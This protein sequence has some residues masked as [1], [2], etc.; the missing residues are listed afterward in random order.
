MRIK[1]GVIKAV[2]TEAD[3]L[4][5]VGGQELKTAFSK[6]RNELDKNISEAITTGDMSKAFATIDEM[7]A[8]NETKAALKEVVRARMEEDTAMKKQ[9][10]TE[11]VIAMAARDARRALD[12]LAAGL[13]QFGSRTEAIG[14][15]AEKTAKK[16]QQEL[17]KLLG[18]ELLESWTALIPLIMC[19]MQPINKLIRPLTS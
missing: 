3:L 18:K 15:D 17:S 12:A 16:L 7:D 14:N 4:G 13:E 19:P 9:I 5:D 11:K 8:S 2:Q 1:T 10:A 6:I